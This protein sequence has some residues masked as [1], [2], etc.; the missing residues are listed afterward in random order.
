MDSCSI[1]ATFACVSVYGGVP[2]Q[3]T[4][5]VTVTDSTCYGAGFKVGPMQAYGTPICAVF[6]SGSVLRCAVVR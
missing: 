4:S 1:A 5:S 3:C 6:F 2:P